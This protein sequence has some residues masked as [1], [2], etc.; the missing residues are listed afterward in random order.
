[1]CY[2]YVLVSSEPRE[3]GSAIRQ[4]REVNLIADQTT[5]PETQNVTT[6]KTPEEIEKLEERKNMERV[7]NKAAEQAGETETRYDQDH[8]LFTK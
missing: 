3:I 5:G 2:D 7:A 6:P 8:G 4:N 1:M